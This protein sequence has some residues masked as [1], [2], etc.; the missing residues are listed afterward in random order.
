MTSP[1]GAYSIRNA[2]GH[3][4]GNAYTLA[5]AQLWAAAPELVA[6]L[7][8]IIDQACHNG[9]PEYEGEDTIT[10]EHTDE[11]AAASAVLAKVK[12]EGRQTP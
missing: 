11:C 1:T 6:A 4:L 8:G 12:T 2:Q 9:C 5:D 3:R 10:I 7:S